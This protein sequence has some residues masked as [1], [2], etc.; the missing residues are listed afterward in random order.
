MDTGGLELGL[1]ARLSAAQPSPHPALS[2]GLL[3]PQVQD[4][5][6]WA[7]AVW[8]ELQG[9]EGSQEPSHGLPTLLSSHRQLRAELE[10]REELH[11]RASQLGQQAL[12][13]VVGTPI[14]EV[15]PFLRRPPHLP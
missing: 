5:T 12:V 11:Q 7:A 6:S 14:K 3:G 8:W 15:G 4:Y 13:A 2:L 10:A 9:Q 1:G